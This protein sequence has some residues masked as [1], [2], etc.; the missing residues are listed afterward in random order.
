MT[1]GFRIRVVSIQESPMKLVG[2]ARCFAS[3]LR[4]GN[5]GLVAVIALLLLTGA[6]V[7]ATAIDQQRFLRPYH[8]VHWDCGYPTS[9]IGVQYHSVQVHADRKIGGNVLVTDNF[10]FKETWRVRDG[11]WI[12][13]AGNGLLQDVPAT[14]LGG[15]R[16]ALNAQY[17]D[18]QFTIFDSSGHVVH[19]D[20]G[21]ISFSY[22]IDVAGRAASLVDVQV[23]A[24]HT[25]EEGFPATCQS[26]AALIGT[27]SA[28]YQAPR[29]IGSTDFAMGYYEYLP[30]SY[31]ASGAKSPLLVAL[32]GYGE[33]GDGTPD[34]LQNLLGTGIPRFIT[35]GGW[36]TQR[37]FVVL[38]LQHVEEPPGFDGTPCIGK[39]YWATCGMQ[40]QH[41][42]G[43]VSPTW[44]TTPDE[45]HDFVTY[46]VA[47][48][49][50]D[51]HRVY[52]T[53]LSCGGFATWEY[54]AKYGDEQAA[55]AVPISGNG[56]PA[57]E[58]AGCGLTS[59][60]TWAFHGALDPIVDPQNAIDTMADLATCG[61]PANRTKLTMFP[62]L[63]HA[64]WDE[65]YSG[66]RGADIYS[67]MLSFRKP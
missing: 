12:A 41:D 52:V 23:S 55:A 65:A 51:P 11:R 53:G 29:P 39:P 31:R 63:D 20:I 49:N 7:Q 6:S 37:P 9:D 66:S 19:R 10:N 43:H 57:W 44:C 22:T 5:V 14:P 35:G 16:Y 30:P 58:S 62:D 42:E 18:Q 67:W 1:R 13:V 33:N 3:L 56:Q 15:S 60:A 26:V 38:A 17:A 21:T 24:P 59:V 28:R 32:N 34:G 25:P 54:I 36:P 40:L 45:V 2:F 61:V 47:H 64:G 46:A 8:E 27:D 50:V 4:S 48:Y